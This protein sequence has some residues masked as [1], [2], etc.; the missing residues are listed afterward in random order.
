MAQAKRRKRRRTTA[1][2]TPA[3]KAP[4]RRRKR[5]SN[6]V[7][8]MPL[9]VANPHRAPSGGSSTGG[10]RKRRRKRA[11]A[12]PKAAPKRRR[13]RRSNPTHAPLSQHMQHQGKRRR[14]KRRSNPIM[15][16]SLLGIVRM[17]LAGMAGLIVSR[18]A[19]R[20]Y[21]T[22]LS[23]MV[24]G[25]EAKADPKHWRNWLDDVMRIIVQEAGVLIVYEAAKRANLGNPTDR[26]A[27]LFA[28]TAETARTTIGLAVS[29]WSP[30]TD[31][32]RLGLDGPAEPIEYAV[33]PDNGQIYALN[34]HT[35]G[36]DLA[37]VMEADALGELIES[38]ALAA[39]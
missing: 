6:P 26:M 30:T 15:G 29:R 35:G 36:W 22:H 20:L 18:V 32:A 2:N 8:M 38:E 34:P 3:K 14:R 16:M 17:G 28:G 25:D 12:A 21:V 5:R 27:F 10:T 1:P 31:R 33:D 13:K 11:G 7:D 39:A 23:D 19:G 37:G 9:L 24:R 4:T